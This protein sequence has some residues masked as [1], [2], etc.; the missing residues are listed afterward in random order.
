MAN[1]QE[2]RKMYEIKISLSESNPLIWRRVQVPR[3]LTLYQL[4]QVIQTAMGW[5]DEHLH[6]FKIGQKRYASSRNEYA[7]F[8]NSMGNEDIA[9]LNGVAKPKSKTKI[10]YTY[11]FGD[12]WQHDIQIECELESDS[13]ERQARCVAGENACPPEDSGG[14]YGYYD[15]LDT[16]DDPLDSE[17]EHTREWLGE[18]FDPKHFDRE[19]TNRRLSQL[20]V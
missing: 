19:V 12:S 20:E 11:D 13:P 8:D 4:H 3:D 1:K 16:L 9:R 15:K 10:I 5:D 2:P 6:E 7:D 18:D 14:L 17:Y